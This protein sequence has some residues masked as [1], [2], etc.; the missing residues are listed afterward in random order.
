[1]ALWDQLKSRVADFSAQTK[2]KVGQFKTK[3]FANASMA[4]SAL[5][6]AADGSIDPEERMRTEGFIR[7]NEALRVFPIDE[8]LEKFNFYAGK[9][10]KDYAFGKMESIATIGK[11]KSKPDQAR[12]VI[13]L[14]IVI[15]GADGNFD[16]NEKRAVR[17]AC[18]AVNIPTG[19]FDL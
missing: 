19:A 13:Q 10:E 9:L 5:I 16:E 14:G 11:L 3:E 12:T 18:H 15:G 1:M 17:E 7:S 6:A 8:L 2:T 4:M